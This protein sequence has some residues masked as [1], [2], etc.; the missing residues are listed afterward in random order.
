MLSRLDVT[1]GRQTAI[2]RMV[3]CCG[4]VG[5]SFLAM[6]WSGLLPKTQA[7]EN[8]LPNHLAAPTQMQTR[9]HLINHFI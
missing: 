4:F 1:T 3:L 9:T 2:K 7:A 8:I 5:P 6:A